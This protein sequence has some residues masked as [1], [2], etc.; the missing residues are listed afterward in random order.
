M[1]CKATQ[2]GWAIVKGSDKTRSTG[3]GNGKPLQYSCPENPMNSVKGEKDI[4]STDA[5]ITCSRMRSLAQ[6]LSPLSLSTVK[7]NLF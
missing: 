2:D 1:L 3:G 5:L 6:D 7:L 4:K